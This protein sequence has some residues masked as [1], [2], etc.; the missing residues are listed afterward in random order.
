MRSFFTKFFLIVGAVIFFASQKV[1]AMPEILPLEKV[2]SGMSGVGYT[3]VDNSGNI[4][5]FNVDIIGLM[6]NGKGSQKMIMAKASGSV[7]EK[8]G[9]VLQGMSGSPVYID[10][11]LVGA[12]ATGLKEMSPYTFFITP[13]ESMLKLWE[14]PDDKAIN[15]YIKTEPVAE[16]KEEEK[17]SDEE[18]KPEDKGEEE[19]SAENVEVKTPSEIVTPPNLENIS[20][21]E[22]SAL[23]FSGFDSS[24]LNF[25]KKE[26]QPLGFEKFF[27]IS[28]TK[29]ST[30]LKYNA[31]LEPGGAMGVA[32]VFGDFLVG[33]TGTVTAVDDKKV[34]GFGHSFTHAGNV[35]FFLTDSAVVGTISGENGAGVKIASVGSIIG[36]VNQDRE[37]G[38]SGIIGK[39]PSVVPIS[40]TVNDKTSNATDTYNAAIAYNENLIPKLGASIAY[41]ALSKTSDSLAESTVDVDFSIKTNVAEGGVFSRQNTFYN[42][43]DVGQVAIVEL[44]QAL[45]TICSNTTKESNIFSIDV[46]M[47][48]D[49]ERRTASLVSAVPDKKKVKPGE[50]VN[51]TVTLQPYRKAAETVVVPYTVPLTRLEGPMALDIHGGAVVAVAQVAAATP[52]GI[53]TPSTVTPEQSYNDKIKKLLTAGK[54]NQ[55]VVEPGTSIATLKS[56]KEMK[57]DL[58]RIKKLQEK[59]AKSGKKNLVTKE[60]KID[61]NYIIDN[62]IQVIIEVD[63]A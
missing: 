23:Y 18:T 25:L 8:T 29:N 13:I 27:T 2:E 6:D 62:V 57:R 38:V 4:E 53:I 21:E 11:K 39:F 55:L 40:V 35:N 7:I 42:S 34:L 46:T 63:K 45:N 61:T 49:D 33:A 30:D 28:S 24:G 48:R 54:N 19:K 10:G 14:M 36:R 1:F 50:T 31:T 51:L 22:K 9:G 44:L 3:I 56:E 59:L 12:L 32:V 20:L 16:V 60:T 47:T 5:P 37:A 41:T 17:N 26:M 58:A 15:Q 52:A 43:A